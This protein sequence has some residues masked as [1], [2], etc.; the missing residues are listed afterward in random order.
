MKEKQIY[1]ESYKK[2]YPELGKDF[3]PS[4]NHLNDEFKCVECKI[5]KSGLIDR[6]GEKLKFQDIRIYLKDK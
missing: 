3:L 5:M 1:S 6:D 2:P 4:L